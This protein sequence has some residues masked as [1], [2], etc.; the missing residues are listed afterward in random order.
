M[1][2]ETSSRALILATCLGLGLSNFTFAAPGSPTERTPKAAQPVA[3]DVA[4]SP[5]GLLKGQV[6]DHQGRPLA[7]RSVTILEQGRE[8][9]RATTDAEGQFQVAGLKSGVYVVQSDDIVRV[10]R[11]WDAQ[12]APPAALNAAVLIAGEP[13]V[14]GQGPGMIAGLAGPAIVIGATIVGAIL[15]IDE[16]EDNDNDHRTVSP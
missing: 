15:I 7:D 12:L 1:R 11:V 8:V 6:V 10:L 16:I 3:T 4:L 5:N 9:A 2:R 14:R 13:T